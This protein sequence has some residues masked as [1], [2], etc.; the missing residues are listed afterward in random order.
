MDSP[1]LVSLESFENFSREPTM[2]DGKGGDVPAFS[3]S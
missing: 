2:P 3:R 1:R